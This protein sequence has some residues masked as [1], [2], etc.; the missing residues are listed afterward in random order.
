MAAASYCKTIFILRRACTKNGQQKRHSGTPTDS[1]A[2][3]QNSEAANSEKKKRGIGFWIFAIVFSPKIL[4]V[5]IA[6]AS[7]TA[8]IAFGASLFFWVYY[9]FM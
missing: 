1:K 8:K 6:R 3:T 4:I 2:D 5:A 7:T 9:F